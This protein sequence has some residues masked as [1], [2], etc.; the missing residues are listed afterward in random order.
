M[1]WVAIATQKPERNTDEKYAVLLTDN[2]WSLP[3]HERIVF[4]YWLGNG[5]YMDGDERMRDSDFT[6]W[7]KWKLP[8]V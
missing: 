5:F 1:E 6:H 4:A 3:I 8:S 7:M 2:K